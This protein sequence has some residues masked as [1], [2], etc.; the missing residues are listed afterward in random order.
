VVDRSSSEVFEFFSD[1]RNLEKLTPDF[2]RFRVLG[3]S[4]PDLREGTRIDYRLA[5][6]GMPV[7]WQSRIDSWLPGARFIDSQTRGPYRRWRHTHEFEPWRGGTIIRDRVHYE[8]PFGAVGDLLAGPLVAR[9]V[10][11]IFAFRRARIAELF[12]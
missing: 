1:A 7:R 6:H 10:S 3:V 11:A 8:L 2:L 12:G 5:L 9:D 4:T